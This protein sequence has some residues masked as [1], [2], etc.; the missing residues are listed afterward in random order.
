MDKEKHER[1]DNYVAN[2]AKAIDDPKKIVTELRKL[3]KGVKWEDDIYN[4]ETVK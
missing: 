2:G 3:L 4:S 1:V